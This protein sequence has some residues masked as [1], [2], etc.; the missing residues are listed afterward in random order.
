MIGTIFSVQ[1]EWDHPREVAF[2]TYEPN[3]MG[4]NGPRKMKVLIPAMNE[5]GSRLTLEDKAEIGVLARPAH[6]ARVIKL[7]NKVPQWNEGSFQ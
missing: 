1:E 4:H 5:D 6:A 3:L 7:I 2:I